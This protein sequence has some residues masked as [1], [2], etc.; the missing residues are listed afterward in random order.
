MRYAPATCGLFLVGV[1]TAGAA[2]AQ[3]EPLPV[4]FGRATYRSHC[5]TCHGTDARGEGP[6]ADRLRVRPPDLTL[7]AR[8]NGGSYPADMV[9]KIIDGRQPVKGHGGPDMPIW[10]DA[11]KDT[12]EGYSENKVKERIDGLVEY[13]RSLQA[14]PPQK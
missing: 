14:P 10:G 8:R 9:H 4:L 13:L 5:A 7:L 3:D 1:L 11:F 12:S 2:V 6:L